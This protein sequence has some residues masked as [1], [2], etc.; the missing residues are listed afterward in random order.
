MNIFAGK[1]KEN[2]K[3]FTKSVDC[4][5]TVDLIWQKGKNFTIYF[6]WKSQKEKAKSW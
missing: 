6:C 5:C 4:G 3:R 1:L 2:P